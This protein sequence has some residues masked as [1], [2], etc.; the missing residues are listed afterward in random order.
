MARVHAR[1]TRPQSPE[2][3][4]SRAVEHAFLHCFENRS[5]VSEK[6]LL[7]EGLRY[8][9]GACTIPELHAEFARHK[10][11]VREID[12][13]RMVTTREILAEEKE[14][15]R[16]VRNGR[17]K[18]RSLT[19]FDRDLSKAEL[20]KEQKQ[21]VKHLWRSPDRVM[22]IRGAAGVGK[23]R[24][25]K[26]A[27]LG[28]AANGT[29]VVTL[30][31]TADASRDVLRREGFEE[32]DT[33]ARFLVDE[34]YRERARGGGVVLVDEASLLGTRTLTR[35][36]RHAEQLDARVILVGDIRQYGSVER[37]DLQG[38]SPPSAAW[39]RNGLH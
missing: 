11:I 38:C 31:P 7:A 24:L 21:A 2:R 37:G 6:E 8:G 33:V 13:R 18:C 29:E 3:I 34:E 5:V 19:G 26:E 1:E 9:L 16:F 36:L 15:V 30:A 4:A 25:L 12:G 22:L 35:L 17:G 39:A 14:I 32:A 27:V 28:I 23:T 10:P 20:S